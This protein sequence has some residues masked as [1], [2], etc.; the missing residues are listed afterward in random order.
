MQNGFERPP[1]VVVEPQP[2]WYETGGSRA[3]YWILGAVVAVVLI[4][5][6]GYGMS[7][8]LMTTAYYEP[9]VQNTLA[10]PAPLQPAERAR[11]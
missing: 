2:K 3:S 10:Q 1:H 11:Q 5:A 9:A 7:P 8:N 6:M 4:F